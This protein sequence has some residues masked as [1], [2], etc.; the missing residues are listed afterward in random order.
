M[1]STVTERRSPARALWV[2]HHALACCLTAALCS[3]SLAAQDGELPMDLRLVADSLGCD[4]VKD[5]YERPGMIEA[6]FTYGVLG[7][8]ASE[9][10]AFWCE[11]RTD[12]GARLVIVVASRPPLQYRWWNPPA[13]LSVV[14]EADVQLST[15]RRLADPERPG[16]ERK[17]GR[18][19]AIKSEYDGVVT[20]FVHSEGE[21]YF[22]VLH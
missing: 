13:G 14:E 16:P 7:G 21:W 22:R 17:V 2:R 4:P 1:R 12:R 3:T 9:S 8:A 10:A 20:L 6:P 11:S 18:T 15:F 19:R 5:F